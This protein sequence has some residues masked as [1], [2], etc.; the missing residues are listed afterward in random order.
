[1]DDSDQDFVDFSS[2][3]LK[4]FR[5]KPGEATKP[6]RTADR[7]TSGQTSAKEQRGRKPE[8]DSDGQEE[9]QEEEVTFRGGPQGSGDAASA[10][11]SAAQ[12]LRAKD[13]VLLQMQKFKRSSPQKMG[14]TKV[15]PCRAAP[16][17][18]RQEQDGA[19]SLSSGSCAAGLQ[20][21][22]AL[23]LRLQLQMDQEAAEAQAADL[24]DGGLFFCQICQRDLSHMTAEGR[25]HHLNRC[26]D[27]SEAAGSA[28][29][30]SSGGPD[31]P[32]CGKKFQSQK[33]FWA[34]LKRCSSDMGVSAAELLQALQARAQEGRSAASSVSE[35]AG[36]KRKSSS[37]SKLPL[38]KKFR[39][40]QEPLDE[41]TMVALALSTSL[42]EKERA[43]QKEEESVAALQTEAASSH[44][45]AAGVLKWRSD[46]G[47]GH[48]KKKKKKAAAPRPP[49]L[50]LVQDAET[51]SSRLQERVS[52]L[53]LRCRDPSPPTPTRQPSTLPGR[54]GDAP[55]WCKSALSVEG[56]A[57]PPSFRVAELQEFFTPS[58]SIKSPSSTCIQPDSSLPSVGRGPPA[59]ESHAP[60]PPL[61]SQNASLSLTP[62]TPGTGELSV[63]SQALRDL[64]ELA[65]DGMTLTQYGY[66]T[67]VQHLSGFIQEDLEQPVEICSSRLLGGAGDSHIQ[68]ERM[69]AQSGEGRDAHSHRPA[70]L[71]RL[72]A[73]L[74]GMVNNPQLS[75]VQL[76][77]DSGEVYH[78]HSFMV[79]ARC[80]L[81]AE[82]LHESGFTVQE[83]GSPAAQR[84]VLSDVPGQAVFM[85]LQYL[86]TAQ[87]S[88]PAALQPH[89]LELASRFDLQELQQLSGLPPEDATTKEREENDLHTDQAFLDL[90]RSMWNEDEDA[91]AD[92]DEGGGDGKQQ[93][94]EE[95]MNEEELEEIYEFAATQKKEEE[96]ED[97]EEQEEAHVLEPRK[98]FF[99][100]SDQSSDCCGQKTQT[101]QGAEPS[102]T[103]HLRWTQ[104]RKR[105]GSDGPFL[106]SSGS[107]LSPPPRTFS[108]PGPGLS[109]GP[110]DGVRGDQTEASPDTIRPLQKEGPDV[111]V[112]S[113]SDDEK[114]DA[115]DKSYTQIR[116]S[117]PPEGS[118][119][120]SWLTFTPVQAG[121]SSRS[122]STQTRSSMCRTK[123][124]S[125]ADSPAAVSSPGLS[126]G[127]K[128][129]TC[130]RH[131]DA[132]V[133]SSQSC[134]SGLKQNPVRRRSLGPEVSAEQKQPP[135]WGSALP[136]PQPCI[137]TPLQTDHHQPAAPPLHADII[138]Q[139]RS[140]HVSPSAS[141][142]SSCA[143]GGPSPHK[144]SPS[145][146]RRPPSE[147][148]SWDSPGFRVQAE[149]GSDA[150]AEQEAGRRPSGESS[151]Q[152]S[153]M[154]EPPIA[155]D[156]SWGLDVC[157]E[158]DPARFSLR[159]E[160]GS[161]SSL[162][163]TSRTSSVLP[164][165]A[166]GTTSPPP[167]SR[168]SPTDPPS[169]E[170]H[171]SFLE[172]RLWD[173]WREEEEELPLSQRVNPEQLLKTPASSHRK[174]R[175][176]VVPITPMPSFS[177]MD[178]PELKGKLN[179]FGVR[180]LPKRQMILKLKE[181]H[182][183]THQLASSD[184]EEDTP[185]QREE[186]PSVSCDQFKEPR[187]PAAADAVKPS[188]G[189]DAGQ[190]SASQGSNTSSAGCSDESERSNQ[191]FLV[192]SDGDSDSDGCIS[193]SQAA[194]R[195][196]DR[197]Q[198]VRNFILSHPEL[199]GRI[200]QYQPLVLS[201]LQEQL[202]AAGIRLGAAKLVD[203]L[204]SQCITFTTAKPGRPAPSRCRGNRA[205]GGAKAA[206]RKKA[207]TANP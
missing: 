174:R 39:R 117:S 15:K 123:L 205:G 114:H 131:Q 164:A 95:P 135:S 120:V 165:E 140:F 132:S 18:P 192:S 141:S 68:V 80:P 144:L 4:R 64:M 126:S 204:D 128:R 28:P 84:V 188:R 201:R 79:Y 54:T 167:R 24:E 55:L 194:T 90:L 43:Q 137:S 206:S 143:R 179:R 50:L 183:Y 139:R 72:S 77:V 48:G 35:T 106:Q 52:A 63:G 155:Y 196:Q 129:P 111:I 5:K 73:D 69:A 29:S 138:S 37:K 58:G 7:P 47:R 25:T 107:S 13:K 172:S 202:K 133:S 96:S 191:E 27:E 198:A 21:D 104:S 116:S 102:S 186:P 59:T 182:Q 67:A 152:Q 45:A 118:P 178:T 189:A 187:A 57:G 41:E 83:E 184:S 51:V 197:L 176:S 71:S 74:S 170:S 89:M 177:D 31:C 8:E 142:S 78:A 38:R 119:E 153:F 166:G 121:R 124:F 12:H 158:A 99:E 49:P 61:C 103:S 151:A 125:G 136:V 190:L 53:L 162:Q 146:S 10:S 93:I 200:L 168:H 195:L 115:P 108:L 169:T 130:S 180:P 160:D 42:L 185:P 148:S 17:P 75:D 23:A 101:V 46:G 14:L 32:I 157:E 112:L 94:S 134:V 82:M 173:S 147:S 181:I 159:L 86:Y 33:S 56:C 2:K 97:E 40:K 81:L 36:T 65:E 34:H 100:E 203:Y 122:S 88:V 91:A 175:V 127:S 109:P 105:D 20:G 9:E 85:L 22:E 150:D 1:M 154:D 11:L 193:S 92:L 6:S 110:M 163:E 44:C 62:P 66:S 16:S 98:S 145:P 161:G 70:A 76:Q 60:A 19:A 199:Y 149:A 3:L 171:S 87:C 30:L 26:L 156:D 207:A 113:D